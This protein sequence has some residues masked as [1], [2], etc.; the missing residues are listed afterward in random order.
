MKKTSSNTFSKPIQDNGLDAPEVVVFFFGLGFL[1]CLAAW[2]L[3]RLSL[4][5]YSVGLLGLFYLAAGA[6]FL[7]MGCWMTWTA[8]KGK[9]ITCDRMLNAVHLKGRE[10]LLDVG[11]GRGM[12]LMVAARK[13]PKGRVVGLDD[14][15]QR[16]LFGNNRGQTLFRARAVGL[17]STVEVVTGDMRRMPFPRGSFDVVTACLSLH[18]IKDREERIKALWEMARVLKKKGRLVWQDF[19]YSRQATEDLGRLGFKVVQASGF[20]YSIFP[21]VHRIIAVKK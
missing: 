15:S 14:W 3:S 10:R 2:L 7:I 11:C 20:L 13:L 4:H 5:W 21:P 12:T 17:G 1:L 8:F 19:Q 6:A 18:R 9:W 16:Y